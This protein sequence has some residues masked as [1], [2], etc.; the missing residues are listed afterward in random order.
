MIDTFLLLYV[1]SLASITDTVILSMA[2]YSFAR[3]SD[4]DHGV[5]AC[6][7]QALPSKN[8][9]FRLLGARCKALFLYTSVIRS[10]LEVFDTSLPF[11]FFKE[12]SD[13][14]IE[15]DVVDS[16]VI[17]VMKPPQYRPGAQFK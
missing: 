14:R 8:E 1:N 12:A 15:E 9:T 3:Y 6:Q 17:V 16:K 5:S 2:S 13:R 7:Q 4:M 11:P 10:K